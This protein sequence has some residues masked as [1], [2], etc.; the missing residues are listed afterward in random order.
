MATKFSGGTYVNTTFTGGTKANI[1]SAFETQ[2]VNAG[3]TVVSGSGTTNLLMQTAQDGTTLNQGRVRFKD[4]SGTC[5]QVT[6]ESVSGTPAQTQ[7]SGVGCHLLPASA[8][9]FRILASKYR[10]ECF[11]PGVSAAREFICAGILW[12]PTPYQAV[13][14]EAIYMQGNSLSDTSTTI[15]ASFRTLLG[16]SPNAAGNQAAIVN[17]SLM[18]HPNGDSNAYPGDIILRVPAGSYYGNYTGTPASGPINAYRWHDNALDMAD[19]LMAWG[20]LYTSEALIRG[21]VYD[22]TVISDSFTVDLTDT[23]TDGGSSHDW[24][25]LTGSSIGSGNN[26]RGTIWVALN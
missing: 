19:P 7:S 5:V 9:T 12:I 11:V 13:V 14:T 26:P 18:Q 16:M 2:L 8:K 6:I 10:V 22:W 1:I 4:N 3:W 24:W 20:A 25:A 21:Q 15:P 17:G 23:W